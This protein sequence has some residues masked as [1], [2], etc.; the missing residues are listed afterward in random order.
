MSASMPYL[1]DEKTC[2]RLDNKQNEGVCPRP[3]FPSFQVPQIL[4]PKKRGGKTPATL[5]KTG[6][7]VLHEFNF[8][9]KK[10]NLQH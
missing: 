8:D 4:L 2:T 1:I 9:F 3:P 6:P 10:E 7:F 5:L